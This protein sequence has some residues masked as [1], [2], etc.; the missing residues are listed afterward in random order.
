MIKGLNIAVLVAAITVS[1]PRLAGWIAAAQAGHLANDHSVDHRS[2]RLG[3]IEAFAEMVGGGVKTLAISDVLTSREADELI[4]QAEAIAKRY[5]VQIYRESDLL[6]SDLFP[7]DIAQGKIVLLIYRN[8]DTLAAYQTLKAD[9]A[10]LVAKGGYQGAARTDIARRLGN[11]LSYPEP[12]I[13]ELLR[14]NQHKAGQ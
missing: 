6:V 10:R 3:E 5:K 4:Q 9:K 1:S 8:D 14:E 11:L 7:E 13:D 12:R 2:Y